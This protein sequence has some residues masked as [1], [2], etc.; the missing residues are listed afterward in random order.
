MMVDGRLQLMNK[1]PPNKAFILAAGKG[2]RLRPYTDKMPKPMVPI[3]GRS[4]IKRSLD[5]LSQ[6]GVNEAVINLHHLGNVLEDHLKDIQ[7]PKII[8]S[9]ENDLLETGG[10]VKKALHNFGDEPFFL[11]NGDALWTDYEHE[12]ALSRLAGFWDAEKMDMLLLLQPARNMI[13]TEGVGD[14]T[15]FEDGRAQRNSDKSGEMM[16]AGVRIVQPSLFENTPDGAFSFLTLMDK[17]ESKG[18]LF[19]IAHLGDWHHI[20]TPGD[21][22]RVDELFRHGEI[23]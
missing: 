18:R 10:G 16:F 11:I 1:T 3:A 2:T 22:E 9:H 17:A 20:S 21:L 19:G 23:A 12:P 8:L 5:K 13:L 4:I 14:Y 15:L 6:A 7:H